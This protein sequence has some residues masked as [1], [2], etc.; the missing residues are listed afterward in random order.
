MWFGKDDLL[1]RRLDMD[2]KAPGTR[3][4]P[5]GVNQ[6]IWST[7][8]TS[9]RYFDFDEPITIERPV[10]AGGNLEQGWRLAGGDS[11]PAPSVEV[12]IVEG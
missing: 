1:I 12:R 5:E 9:V 10:D 8:Q 4:G 6:V 3:S 11:V 7:Y 2:V